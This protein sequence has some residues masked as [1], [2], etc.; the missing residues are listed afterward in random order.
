MAGKAKE[1]TAQMIA[2]YCSLLDQGYSTAQI[3]QQF[4]LCI[5]TVYNNLERISRESGRPLADL[6]P[7]RANKSKKEAPKMKLKTKSEAKSKALAQEKEARQPDDA[8]ADTETE[9]LRK[10]F[11]ELGEELDDICAEIKAI[12]DA[13]KSMPTLG[14]GKDE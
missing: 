7:Q 3:A 14:G 8:D 10:G 6:K 2:Q 12:I 4:G 9:K 5:Q 1:G 11:S 13:E